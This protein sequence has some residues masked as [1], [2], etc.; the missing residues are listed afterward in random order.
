MKT[1]LIVA[2]ILANS[3]FSILTNSYLI[4]FRK[5][6]NMDNFRL[7][8]SDPQ[9]SLHLAINVQPEYDA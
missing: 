8:S 9:Y 4:S 5:G 3:Y 6:L 2:L 1:L 7:I